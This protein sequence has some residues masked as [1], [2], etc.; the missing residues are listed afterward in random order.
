[1][2]IFSLIMIMCFFLIDHMSQ[3]TIAYRNPREILA[4]LDIRY[5]CVGFIV[6]TRCPYLS[7]CVL[8]LA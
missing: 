2:I 5:C 1:M 4:K 3:T 6:S 7:Y 8:I